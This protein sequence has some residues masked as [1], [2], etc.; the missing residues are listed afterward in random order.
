MSD[1]G[2]LRYILGVA[3]KQTGD[4][5][6]LSQEAYINN[7]LQKFRLKNAK[8]VAMPADPNVV[9]YKN[10]GSESVDH[11][12]LSVIDRKPILCCISNQT[13]HSIRSGSMFSLQFVSH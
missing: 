8:T 6:H 4:G 1:M 5:I 3:I 2:P 9:L 13:R 11:R 10:D 12:E 7:L